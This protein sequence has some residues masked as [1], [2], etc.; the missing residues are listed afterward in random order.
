MKIAV[1]A[2]ASSTGALGGAERLYAGLVQALRNEGADVDLLNV[3]S[4][5]TDFESIKE[6]YLNFY[7]LDLNPYDGIISTKAPSYM[8]RHGNHICYLIHTMRVFYD[9]FENE[10][11]FP[12]PS[13][14][15]QRKFIHA[16]DCAAL[17]PRRVK[18]IFSIG[19]QVS[20]RLSQYNSLASEVLHPA[21]LF[22]NYRTGPYGD[23]L[24][25][26]GRLHRWK[27]VD[28]VIKAMKYT[29]CPVKLKIAGVGEDEAFFRKIAGR[30]RR[31]EFLGR[32]SDDE[33][34]DLYAGALAVPFVPINEDYGY[35][36]LEAFQSAKP[37]ITCKDSG[38]PAFFVKDQYNGF[39]CDPDPKD[40]GQ[41]IEYLFNNRDKA[42]E[43]GLNGRLTA[44]QIGWNRIATTLISAL[45]Q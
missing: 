21:L 29:Q 31:I 13:L 33:L 20:H 12:S 19:H 28:L 10:F 5:E 35:V 30:D 41:K 17:D 14:L 42:S 38:E 32:V 40:L 39:V 18:K 8:A 4:D 26:P 7:D 45:R 36:T 37:V 1:I 2:V 6:S 22:D 44:S 3:V 9:M 16:L 34:I 23:Y 27:R 11:P 15:E 24:F 43:L 25:M